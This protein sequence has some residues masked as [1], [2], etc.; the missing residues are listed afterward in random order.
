MVFLNNNDAT[1][2]VVIR[3][4]QASDHEQVECLFKSTQSA[5]VFESIKSKLRAPAT[6]AVWI[7]IWSILLMMVPKALHATIDQVSKWTITC[8][9]VAITIW[10]LIAGFAIV[11][12]GSDRI[13]IQ[14][15]VDEALANDLKDPEDYY[16][17]YKVEE[18]REQQ[19]SHF[20]VLTVDD[21]VC[22]MIGLSCN[23]K[24]VEDQRETLPIEWRQFFA[25]VLQVLRLPIPAFFTKRRPCVNDYNDKKRIFAYLQLPKTATINR[26]TISPELQTG[27]L[28]TLLLHKAIKHASEH[29]INRVFAMTNECSTTAEQILTKR[30]G[31]TLMKRYNLNFFGE[32]NKLF[33]VRV[34]EWIEK[35]RDDKFVY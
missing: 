3:T 14:N 12:I 2:K 5:S 34:K 23:A 10:W 26:W 29:G 28:S 1:A 24:D 15:R 27:G 9:R 32:H 25:A 18:E 7:V 11:F 6:W 13:E 20:W 8:T 21:K 19:A 16:L 17:N 31:F 4:Y 22:G 35:N 30:H 33:A